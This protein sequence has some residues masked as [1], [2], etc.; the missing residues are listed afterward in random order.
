MGERTFSKL[1]FGIESA[2]AQ[3]MAVAADTLLAGAEIPPVNPD[4]AP[5]FPEDNLGVRAAGSRVRIDQYLA[6]NSIRI[7]Q[8][9][10]QALPAI[11]SCGLKGGV[12]P[13]EQTPSQND[14]LWAHTP[15]M[16]ASNAPDSMTLEA[17]DD[18]QA[19]EIEYVMFKRIRMAGV[20]AQA[21]EESPV[22]LEAEYFGR[23]VTPTA[24]TGSIS[25]PNMTDIVA[26]LSRIYINATWAAKG[27]TEVTSLLRAWELEILTGLHPKFFG[28]GNRYFDAHGQS[29]ID[30][31]LG[32]T[33]EGNASADAEWDKYRIGTKQA[34]R[35][36]IDSGVQIGTGVTHKLTLD[37]WG[38]YETVIPLS[39]EDRGNNL[40]TAMFRGRYDP[41][42][43]QELD[44]RVITNVAA[45]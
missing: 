31:M 27:T 28:S 9:Y 10:F 38:A 30:V 17:G 6:E 5:S 44:V 14:M 36:Q 4:R 2:V 8:C 41:T 13:A 23:Q 24:F 33:Y 25:V 20:I 29:R 45:I 26:K 22:A 35:V 39:N 12:T 11:L 34:I 7:P 42:G 1:Q 21:G 19:Y 3:G 15:S 37:V 18:T 43:A 40:H 16:T 32:L